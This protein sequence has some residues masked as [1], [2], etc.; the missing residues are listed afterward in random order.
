[1]RISIYYNLKAKNK[2][3]EMSKL[4][5]ENIR[6][7]DNGMS[8]MRQHSTTMIENFTRMWDILNDPAPDLSIL[9]NVCTT[10]TDSKTRAHQIYREILKVSKSSRE[11]LNLMRV[12]CKYVIFDDLLMIEVDETLQH[13]EDVDLADSVR[14]EPKEFIDSLTRIEETCAALSISFNLENLG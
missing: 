4:R 2:A 7:F 14:V 10:I 6:V 5:Y 13:E 1:M 3:H 9:E 8:L 11:F 12:Y